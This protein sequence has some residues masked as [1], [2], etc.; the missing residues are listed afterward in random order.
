MDY[1]PGI[2]KAPAVEH[3]HLLKA[4]GSAVVH[5]A[6]MAGRTWLSSACWS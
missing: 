6:S 5:V 4:M 2:V 1:G 3:Q